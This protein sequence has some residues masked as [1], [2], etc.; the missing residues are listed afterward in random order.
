[1]KY[2]PGISGNPLG[3]PKGAKDKRRDLNQQQ[4]ML[5]RELDASLKEI[6]R[7][8]EELEDQCIRRDRATW[9]LYRSGLSFS[10]LAWWL[11]LS[12]P[13]A[14]RDRL[15]RRKWINPLEES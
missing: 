6:D 15:V 8:S 2:L 9:L 11:N 1:M 4:L 5:G 7:L 10:R 13:K 14:V 3:R 12:T